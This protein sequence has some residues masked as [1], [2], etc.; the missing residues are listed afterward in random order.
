MHLAKLNR[1]TRKQRDRWNSVQINVNWCSWKEVYTRSKAL[2]PDG[3]LSEMRFGH[4]ARHFHTNP[5]LIFL[6]CWSLA[7][8]CNS[9]PTCCPSAC[10]GH[11]NS[12]QHL[13]HN[14]KRHLYTLHSMWQKTPSVCQDCTNNNFG[15]WQCA[16]QVFVE[17]TSGL[18]GAHQSVCTFW[19]PTR[20]L[21][22]LKKTEDSVTESYQTSYS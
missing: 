4:C 3:Y 12:K 5:D 9:L 21:H 13:T 18:N 1:V 17:M 11:S 6:R 8:L 7:A 20:I 22:N 15:D 14:Q 2:C 10:W 16:G 19:K